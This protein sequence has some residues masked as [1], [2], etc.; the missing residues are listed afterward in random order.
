[1]IFIPAID[2]LYSWNI[3]NLNNLQ[4]IFVPGISFANIIGPWHT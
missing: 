1:M 2:L 3:N 4:N